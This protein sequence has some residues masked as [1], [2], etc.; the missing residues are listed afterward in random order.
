MEEEFPSL[1]PILIPLRPLGPAESEPPP[2]TLPGP[3]HLLHPAGIGLPELTDTPS[4]LTSPGP[5]QLLQ[6]PGFGLLKPVN[7]QPPL[8]TPP[9]QPPG[10]GLLEP[11]DTQPP[12]TPPG[13]QHLLLEV[14]PSVCVSSP[15][16]TQHYSHSVQTGNP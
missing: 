11:T 3:Q 5:Q 6:P 1:P 8:L 13:P 7:T 4:P 15:K 14:C 9:L 10:T 2:V 12:L 16:V